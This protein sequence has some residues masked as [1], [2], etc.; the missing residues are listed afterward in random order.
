M[1]AELLLS[2]VNQRR[3]GRLAEPLQHGRTGRLFRTAKWLVRAGLG[4]RLARR[5]GG[6]A[7]HHV[8]SACYLAAGLCFRFAWV[9]AGRDSAT[10]D[11]AVARMARAD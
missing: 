11:E 5:R 8:A 7:T 9:S 3:L 4:L 2:E 6:P 1:T 10:D